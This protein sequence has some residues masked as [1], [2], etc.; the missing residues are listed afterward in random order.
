MFEQKSRCSLQFV[1]CLYNGAQKS[2][3]EMKLIVNYMT[4]SAV[5]FIK[6]LS[7]VDNR[8]LH[9]RFFTI[10][11]IEELWKLNHL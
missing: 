1:G 9:M 7:N 4:E 5:L 10:C 11:N 3:N 8:I 2:S 6:L